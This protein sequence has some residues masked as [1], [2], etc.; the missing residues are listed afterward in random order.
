MAQQGLTDFTYPQITGFRSPN[1][2]SLYGF[3]SSNKNE[4]DVS[5]NNFD[6][7]HKFD[8]KKFN[9][10]F[11][12]EIINADKN[13]KNLEDIRLSKLN[14]QEKYVKPYQLSF[15]QMLIGIKDT[16]FNLTDDLL[17]KKF[18][19]ETFTKQNR[20]F[21]IGLTIIIIIILVYLFDIIFDD[22]TIQPTVAE[23]K[24][25]K[26]YHFHNDNVPTS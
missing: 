9:A 18:Y 5:T 22:N 4:F 19:V 20:L 2:N 1:V 13:N 12:N 14:Y 16:W 23:N 8:I 17:E 21:F 15:S 3:D 7:D 25:V 10:S 11:E 26:I 6:T 24:V